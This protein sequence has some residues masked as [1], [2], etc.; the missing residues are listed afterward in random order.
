MTKAYAEKCY[1][2]RRK[3]NL[4]ST[5]NP[6]LLMIEFKVR[7]RDHPIHSKFWLNHVWCTGDG[8]V[9]VWPVYSM[10]QPIVFLG[11]WSFL[12][13]IFLRSSFKK[14][15]WPVGLGCQTAVQDHSA[16][17]NTVVSNRTFRYYSGNDHGN[18]SFFLQYHVCSVQGW[19][20]N[21]TILDSSYE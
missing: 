1:A 7:P 20:H 10:I 18:S 5:K 8:V 11:V 14:H 19:I 21:L 3:L 12:H 16:R 6:V 15:L 17:I 9:L 13:I 2:R 4:T